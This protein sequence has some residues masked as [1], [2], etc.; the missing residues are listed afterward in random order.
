M[1]TTNERAGEKNTSNDTTIDMQKII[2]AEMII[3][4]NTLKSIILNKDVDNTEVE[5]ALEKCVCVWG[6][7][8]GGGGQSL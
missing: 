2:S 4:I 6:G 5:I 1:R 8:G 7:G 3:I